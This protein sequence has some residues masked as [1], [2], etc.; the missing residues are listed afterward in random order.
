MRELFHPLTEDLELPSVMHA[1]ADP[2]RL[3]LVGRLAAVDGENCSDA[4][5]GI[6]LHKSTLSH[7][8]RVLREAGLTRTT[9]EGRTRMVRLRRS[10]LEGRFPGLLGS[11]LTALER[12]PPATYIT[13]RP[14]GR[15]ATAS[16]TGTSR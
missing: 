5:A 13:A 11:V 2:A 1:L 15:A 14:A 4:G 10:D 16:T 3:E 8:Y 7:H 6:E 9:I 12:S